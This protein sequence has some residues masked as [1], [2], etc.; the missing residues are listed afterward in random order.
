VDDPVIEDYSYYGFQG[1][2]TKPFKGEEMKSLV[3]KI[4]GGVIAG[5][6]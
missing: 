6:E 2:L 4:L 1:A 3:E 5:K